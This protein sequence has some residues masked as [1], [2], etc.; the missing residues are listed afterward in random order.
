MDVAQFAALVPYG[1]AGSLLA[2]AFWLVYTGRL[3]PASTVDKILEAR[4]ERIKALLADNEL[5]REDN[6]A[7][8]QQVRELLEVGRTSAYALEEIRK[9]ASHGPGEG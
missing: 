4:D 1:G 8:Q 5:L 3:M 2:A 7:N 6:R 9:V